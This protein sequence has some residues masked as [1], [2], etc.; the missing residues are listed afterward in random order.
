MNS[1]TAVFLL[2]DNA[3]VA[4]E[5][6]DQ[7]SRA[8]FTVSGT[9]SSEKEA[10]AQLA[11]NPSIVALVDVNLAGSLKGVAIAN[12]LR[13][14]TSLT[15]VLVTPDQDSPVAE[16]LDALEN[17]DL[18]VLPAP[19][20]QLKATLRAALNRAQLTERA[21]V[22]E[23]PLT[24]EAEI[25]ETSEA[26]LRDLVDNSS[27]LIQS[28]A[29]DGRLLFVNRTW[30]ETLGYAKAETGGLN[31]F[32]LIHPDSMEHCGAAFQRIMAGEDVGPMELKF[33]AKDGRTIELE[34]HV[35][36]RIR[37][38]HPTATRGI[39]RD[40]TKRD[41]LA[42]SQRLQLEQ[43]TQFASALLD[44]RDQMG[45][46]ANAFFRYSTT[47]IAEEL[48][49]NRVS[50]WLFNADRSVIECA[51]LFENDT[52][53][54]S[55]GT[56]LTAAVNPSYFR[57]I[58]NHESIVANDARTHPATREFTTTYL[59]PLGITSML[60]VPMRIGLR[61]S[62]V[63]CCENCGSARIWTI[64]EQKFAFAAAGYAMTALEQNARHQA[65][66][67]LQLVN[68][69]LELA[70]RISDTC[71]W[72]SEVGPDRLTL[73]ASWMEMRGYPAAV[74]VISTRQL[75][76]A[77]HPEER[78]T[79]MTAVRNVIH[80]AEDEYRV[81][82]QVA[83]ATGGWIWIRSHGR[84]TSRD[85][86]GR[87]NRI[88]GTNT[89]IS[90]DRKTAE[91]QRQQA[92]FF[93]ALNQTTVDLLSQR[94]K[95]AILQAIVERSTELLNA[96]YTELALLEGEELVVQAFAGASIFRHHVMG[97][98]VSR[99]QAPIAW[100][101]IDQGAPVVLNNLAD[102]PVGERLRQ[103]WNIHSILVIP[104]LRGSHC[105]GVV[106]LLRQDPEQSFTTD[107]IGKAQLFAQLVSLVLHH[108]DIYEDAVR[109]A[110][111]RT[112]E[113]RE[114]EQRFRMVFEHSPVIIGLLSVPEGR[115]VELNPA[116]AAAFGYTREEAIGR[117]SI[118]LGLW[119]NP[120]DRDHYMSLLREHGVV[121]DFETIMNRKNGELFPVI[122]HGSLI[123]IDGQSYS[124]N[125]LQDVTSRIK[126]E[127]ALRVSEERWK[128][129]LEGAGDGVWDWDLV[130][131]SVHYSKRW[132]EMLGYAEDEI[133]DQVAE[134]ESRVHPED[135]ENTKAILTDY[136]EK[137]RGNFRVEIR[138]RCKD[139]SWK[140]ILSRGML[141]SH[142]SRGKPRRLI[143]THTDVTTRRQNE[144][145]V[146]EFNATL[147]DK[148]KER[149]AELEHEMEVRQRV[150]SQY[151]RV[152]DSAQEVIVEID[153]IGN[154]VFLNPAWE[155]VTGYTVEE[156]MGRNFI[157]FVHPDDRTHRVTRF[158]QMISGEMPS[159]EASF[160][161]VTKSGEF[162][163]IEAHT[164]AALDDKEHVSGITGTLLDVTER[165]QTEAEL[166][167]TEIRYQHAITAS[168]DGVW[169][170]DM[171]TNQ[172]YYSPSWEAMFGYGTG[173]AETS[174][175]TFDQLV[176]P[177][178][179]ESM[180]AEVQQYLD[181]EIPHYTR[182]FRMFHRDG[183]PR[184]TLHHAKAI[185]DDE[186]KPARLIGTTAD[187]T[188]RKQAELHLKYRTEELEAANRELEAFS[189]SVSHDLR[190]PLRGID[191]WSLALVED[192]A[193]SLD[194]EGQEVIGRVRS[195]AQRMGRLID[196]LLELARV[197]RTSI[198]AQTVNL[199]QLAEQAVTALRTTHADRDVTIDIAPDL[200]TVG[201]PMLMEVMIQN[202][203]GNAW[204]FTGH[205][206]EAHIEF[207]RT[208]EGNDFT[209]M[210][211]DNGAGFDPAYAGKLF[212]PFQR[213]HKPTEF[214]GTGIGLATVQRIIRRHGGEVWTEAESGKGAT[215]FF[216]LPNPLPD[217][218]ESRPP[219]PISG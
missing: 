202:L 74:C 206:K 22:I 15:V 40:V 178:E 142:D 167:E 156:A 79:V 54:H 105:F 169:D 70:L 177:D 73:D 138:M 28:V 34:G 86:Q 98:R 109:E 190:A 210:I 208:E 162:R 192:Y 27:D 114:T 165:R 213:L 30:R 52:R 87:A 124:L 90:E 201:D 207:V 97:E 194:A 80:G 215:F 2:L 71:T 85:T 140:W 57:A 126:A 188:A 51:D 24:A 59:D 170:W 67:N 137:R 38:G 107:D 179:K 148:V 44:L 83:T 95:G 4:L 65:E 146:R 219:L 91:T 122:Y 35:N 181:R 19:S 78:K 116:A 9:A 174:I 133:V 12:R 46:D 155:S 212:A 14:T 55:A 45:E 125:S 3:S 37:D 110:E 106:S 16:S 103:D 204:K 158:R 75:M 128:F 117:T 113:L 58:A 203:I 200:T 168:Q 60:N 183:S 164:R 112:V 111:S 93:A 149:T 101:A 135:L 88:I 182:E 96:H 26:Q 150:E 104:V 62:G 21:P 145:T 77:I 153:R 31:I 33:V 39:F 175:K 6:S 18:V 214:P 159:A 151:R 195:E 69:R 211:R 61:H 64:E 92:N 36:A 102:H 131:D 132:K 50:V 10:R 172:V 99:D 161:A 189:Y 143:G 1:P 120:T 11:L 72:D 94:D 157:E 152:V 118:E 180:Y 68:H 191:G 66:I 216:R 199:S 144:E 29:D 197:N 171:T 13:E 121:R 196:G 134:W 187:I 47:R 115:V 217:N 43:T 8:G 218:G 173:E 89:N 198:N 108:T 25:A 56:Q 129:A 41:A 53:E 139:D 209:F 176:H 20:L 82:H 17:F 81:E 63:L 76:A 160:R 123:E 186:G 48:N 7:L 185:Y 184:W 42:N 130:T 23:T 49:T 136:L 100:Q 84:V 154:F 163:W 193:D 141:T 166:R 147:E 205:T 127:Q 119:A 5:L 32:S